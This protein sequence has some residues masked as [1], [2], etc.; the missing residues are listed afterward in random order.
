MWWKELIIVVDGREINEDD[1]L[2]VRAVNPIYYHI[3]GMDSFLSIKLKT[4]EIIHTRNKVSIKQDQ[5]DKKQGWADGNGENRLTAGEP[6]EVQ[7]PT[8]IIV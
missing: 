3:K 7:I 2:D 5:G 6:C 4:G 8:R 1:I